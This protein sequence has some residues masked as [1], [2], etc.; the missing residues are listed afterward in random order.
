MQ[1]NYP[2]KQCGG[3]CKSFAIVQE[4]DL[5]EADKLF[6]KL[7]PG[8]IHFYEMDR[9]DGICKFLDLETNKCKIYDK[10]PAICDVTK[11]YEIFIQE[12]KSEISLE[13][14]IEVAVK[15]RCDKVA[16][17]GITLRELDT[18]IKFPCTACGVCCHLVFKDLATSFPELEEEVAE[19][20]RGDGTCKYQNEHTKR[21]DIYESRPWFCDGVKIWEKYFKPAGLSLEDAYGVY[22]KQCIALQTKGFVTDEDLY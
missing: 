12:T 10:R 18:H 14:F 15:I 1:N 9:G 4:E 2:C 20:D 19:M 11:V 5:I 22:E 17:E 7:Y 13:D 3:C 6:Q 16:K 8:N 21:C